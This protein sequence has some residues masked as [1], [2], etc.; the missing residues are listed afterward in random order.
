MNAN[1]AEWWRDDHNSDQAHLIQIQCNTWTKIYSPLSARMMT[2]PN[3]KN[4]IETSALRDPHNTLV[5]GE[6]SRV[7]KHTS[8][9]LRQAWMRARG[10]FAECGSMN[11]IVWMVAVSAA[12]C[13]FP[14]M[15]LSNAF[16][17]YIAISHNSQVFIHEWCKSLRIIVV[18]VRANKNEYFCFIRTPNKEITNYLRSTTLIFS[19]S[20]TST[21]FY[22]I[23]S[24][25][26]WI[27]LS[28]FIFS[29]CKRTK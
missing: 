14:F 11:K 1:T 21:S 16:D 6:N 19:R 13:F 4:Q 9:V 2:S 5:R 7:D 3:G 15:C 26:W 23:Y 22:F 10:I 12:N 27:F 20:I 8:A 29:L 18:A 25:R 17:L 24:V 28:I